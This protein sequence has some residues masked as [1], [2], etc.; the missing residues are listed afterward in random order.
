MYCLFNKQ[1]AMNTDGAACLDG[2]VP[3]MYYRAG[4]GTGV[5]KFHVYFEGG[6]CRFST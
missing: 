5:N 3:V 4:T 6:G 1:D 2:S